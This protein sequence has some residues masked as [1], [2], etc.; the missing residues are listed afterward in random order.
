MSTMR[1]GP[2][3]P[4]EEAKL[5]ERPEAAV[6][7]ILPAYGISTSQYFSNVFRKYAG[8]TPS[9]FRAEA[10]AREG[11]DLLPHLMRLM[12]SEQAVPERRP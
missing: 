11:D 5:G 3:R 1:R 6:T 8:A 12:A 4:E 9:N 2:R 10:R 7:E